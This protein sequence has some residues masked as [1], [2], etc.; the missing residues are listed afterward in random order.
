MVRFLA[1]LA[2]MQ[3]LALLHEIPR[4]K[5]VDA[6]AIGLQCTNFLIMRQ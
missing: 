4:P 3:R 5:A 2:M 1:C 6:I